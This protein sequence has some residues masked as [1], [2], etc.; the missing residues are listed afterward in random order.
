MLPSCLPLAACCVSSGASPPPRIVSESPS[1]CFKAL[2]QVQELSSEHPGRCQ[3]SLPLPGCLMC[4]IGR[5]LFCLSNTGAPMRNIF[6]LQGKKVSVSSR[7][8]AGRDPRG[9]VSMH[10]A[11]PPRCPGRERNNPRCWSW[12]HG[13]GMERMQNSPTV[14]PTHSH[15]AHFCCLCWSSKS[16]HLPPAFPALHRHGLYGLLERA[17]PKVFH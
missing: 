12:W 7:Q 14:V 11:I 6:R 4:L 8:T 15:T 5:L 2:A 9:W 17:C 10:A 16:A 13:Q 3:Q 1:L